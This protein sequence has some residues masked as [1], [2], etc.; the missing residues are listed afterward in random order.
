VQ[1]GTEERPDVTLERSDDG[2]LI[3]YRLRVA[4]HLSC[5]TPNLISDIAELFPAR[6]DASPVSVG[7]DG[8]PQRALR[9]VHHL[10][11]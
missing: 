2:N 9:A 4:P 11:A 3:P 8:R 10:I 5:R 6:G 7:G 1:S